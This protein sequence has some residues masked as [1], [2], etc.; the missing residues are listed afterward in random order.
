M[1]GRVLPRKRVHSNGSPQ[2]KP[3]SS[4]PATV[5]PLA[6]QSC[7]HVL[8]DALEY[9]K[10]PLTLPGTLQSFQLAWREDNGL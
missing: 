5:S 1:R 2:A 4:N 8:G 6:D 3:S 7:A 9:L 10:V